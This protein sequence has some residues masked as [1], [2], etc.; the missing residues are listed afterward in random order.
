MVQRKSQIPLGIRNKN[1][2]SQNLVTLVGALLESARKMLMT[3]QMAAIN[4]I[5]R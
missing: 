3:P 4:P 1:I 5:T 2:N